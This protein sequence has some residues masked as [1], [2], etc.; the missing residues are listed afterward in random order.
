MRWPHQARECTRPTALVRGIVCFGEPWL[1]ERG[2]RHGQGAL[3]AE[4]L[5]PSATRGNLRNRDKKEGTTAKRK[6]SELPQTGMAGGEEGGGERLVRRE[7]VYVSP[8]SDCARGCLVA[9]APS[10][11]LHDAVQVDCQ[12]SEERFVKV[13]ANVRTVVFQIT[14][15]PN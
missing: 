6:G 13:D 1:R 4:R 10:S 5:A 3:R 9:V 15:N 14:G 2:S 7:R 8:G 12:G 11:A